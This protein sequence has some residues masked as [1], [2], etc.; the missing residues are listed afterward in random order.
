M[1]YYPVPTRS[2]PVYPVYFRQHVDVVSRPYAASPPK[3]SC[4]PLIELKIKRASL[5]F[6]AKAAQEN[7]PASHVSDT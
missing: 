1:C 2:L 7:V 4:G 3:S 6:R 5:W